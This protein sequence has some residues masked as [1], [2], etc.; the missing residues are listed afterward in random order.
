VES[1]KNF[2]S[3]ILILGWRCRWCNSNTTTTESGLKKSFTLDD[4]RSTIQQFPFHCDANRC[5]C[6]GCIGCALWNATTRPRFCPRETGRN[7]TP[8]QIQSIP[9]LAMHSFQP[10]RTRFLVYAVAPCQLDP[11]PAV[12]PKQWLSVRIRTSLRSSRESMSKTVLPP[13]WMLSTPTA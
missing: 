3:S 5:V 13:L 1:F 8:K 2:R 9:F 4:F 10:R 6:N 7:R 12:Q 11:I